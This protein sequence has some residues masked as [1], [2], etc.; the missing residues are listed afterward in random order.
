MLLTNQLVGTI[1]VEAQGGIGGNTIS[2]Q[3][4]DFGPGGG[5]AGGRIML[6]G[7]TGITTALAG[8]QPGMNAT[9]RQTQGAAKG[10]DGLVQNIA[11]F[12]LP[13]SIDTVFRKLEI[14]QQPVA[15]QICEYQTTTFSIKAHGTNLSYEWQINRGNGFVPLAADTTFIGVGTST[16]II[17]R[18]RT[19][20]NPYLFR[21]VVIGGCTQ[22]N[23]LNSQSVGINILPAPVSLFTPIITYNTVQFNNTS[24]NGASFIWTFGDGRTGRN[25]DTTITYTAQGDYDVTLRTI[26]NCDTAVY[27]VRVKLN[28]PPKASFVS[29]TTSY[30]TP[31]NIKFT[32]TSSN[33]TVAYKWSFPG[34]SPNSS[35]DANPSVL[36][37]T[38]GIYDVILIATNTNGKDT[39]TKTG[40]IRVNTV[41]TSSFR[42]LQNGNNPIVNFDNLTVGATS[43]VW[44]FGDG[45]TTT[46]ANP[47]HT[48][49]T[50]G[51]FIVKLTATNNCG[52]TSMQD[53]VVLLNRPSATISA[54]QVQGCTPFMVQFTG[55]NA[56]NV[57]SWSWSFPGGTPS[58]STLANPRITYNTEGSYAV[59]LKVS[60][61]AGIYET[62]QPEYIKVQISPKA[63]FTFVVKDTLVT[64]T[65]TSTNATR[66]QWDF[67]DLMTSI[68]PTPP[69]KIYLRNGNYNVTLQA[70]NAFC[71]AA[72]TRQVTVFVVGTKNIEDTEGVITAFPNP[73]DGKLY[74]SFKNEITSDYQLVIT[75]TSGQILKNSTLTRDLIQTLDLQNLARGVYFLQFSNDKLHFVK[76]VVKM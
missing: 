18:P 27:T 63:D 23:S 28:A 10:N 69:S 76:R 66:Y 67:G 43:F 73:T 52:A 40:Y 56:T 44:N 13:L 26:N 61:A 41:P 12:K 22:T 11:N 1:K 46:E 20:L 21:C 49:T 25:R 3:E 72:I 65:N 57:T 48:Y 19:T 60:N 55:Q 34:G 33:N 35:T 2:I 64:F 30:C 9:T 5:G 32:N 14:V 31:A 53:T 58:T 7:T 59:T 50:G 68:S 4:Y 42:K 51:T 71:G 45:T 70:L 74:L 54:N 24:S 39:L 16:L 15:I 17:N 6:T 29:T 36:Y 38:A 47:Q 75:N 8:G 62:T 37:T